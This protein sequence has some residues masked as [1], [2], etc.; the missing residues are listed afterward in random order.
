[1]PP[2]TAI[3]WTTPFCFKRSLLAWWRVRWRLMRQIESA[4]FQPTQFDRNF[5]D[6]SASSGAARTALG[7]NIHAVH[8]AGSSDEDRRRPPV[9]GHNT[10]RSTRSCTE[11]STR[12][13]SHTRTRIRNIPGQTRSSRKR[14]PQSAGPRRTPM[15]QLPNQS[16]ETFSNSY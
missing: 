4:V 11:S 8:Y 9:S 13:N 2:R 12:D 5:G 10:S 3:R 7:G 15:L 1:M 14:L 16:E 6:L